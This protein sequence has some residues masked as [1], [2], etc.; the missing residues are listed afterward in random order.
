MRRQTHLPLPV[1]RPAHLP[2]L[3]RRPTQAHTPGLLEH[4]R[5]RQGCPAHQ[6]EEPPPPAFQAPPSNTPTATPIPKQRHGARRRSSA[7][8]GLR[9]VAK[10]EGAAAFA[11]AVVAQSK[12]Y[13]TGTPGTPQGTPL[14]GPRPLLPLRRRRGRGNAREG[15]PALRKALPRPCEATGW[16]VSAGRGAAAKHCHSAPFPARHAHP[17]HFGGA[18]S[19]KQ[20]FKARLTGHWVPHRVPHKV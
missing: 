14:L 20:R 19:L 6:A 16:A 7:A 8:H 1:R 3:M 9:S 17:R 2:L 18:P 11:H 4:R 13:S 15:A 5:T 10:Q 12:V